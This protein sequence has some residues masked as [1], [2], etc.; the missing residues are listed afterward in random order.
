MAF[1]INAI[2]WVALYNWPELCFSKAFNT[3]EKHM[4]I[5]PH[6]Y[7]YIYIYTDLIIYLID[8]KRC[9]FKFGWISCWVIFIRQ[10]YSNWKC[11]HR[12]RRQVGGGLGTCPLKTNYRKRGKLREIYGIRENSGE[13]EANTKFFCTD[14]GAPTP[15]AVDPF[16]W[17]NYS[18][19]LAFQSPLNIAC[20]FLTTTHQKNP[21]YDYPSCTKMA[22]GIWVYCDRED[23]EKGVNSEPIKVQVNQVY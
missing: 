15:L 14:V 10:A 6:I 8:I 21:G 2:F 13:N 5:A 19:L 1:F 12:H 20:A 17:P 7:I 11:H 9:P 3:I 16:K 18:F 22:Q 23:N 4:D